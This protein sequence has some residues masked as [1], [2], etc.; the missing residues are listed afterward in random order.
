MRAI[1]ATHRSEHF[2]TPDALIDYLRA[3]AELLVVVSHPFAFCRDRSSKV[4]AFA[5]GR[6]CYQKYH[7]IALPDPFA[8]V[9][10]LLLT[11]ADVIAVAR[12]FGAAFDLY[13]GADS[14]GAFTGLLL[15]RAGVVR[16]VIFYVLD[17]NP[18]RFGNILDAVYHVLFLTSARLADCI[19]NCSGR[20]QKL[21][22]GFGAE[23]GKNLLVPHGFYPH[24]KR[25]SLKPSGRLVYVGHL[26]EFC[27][28]DLVIQA[29]P[30]VVKSFPYVRLYVIGYG[31][32]ETELKERVRDLGLENYVEFLG[33]KAHEDVVEF[34]PTCDVGLATYMEPEYWTSVPKQGYCFL[35]SGIKIIEYL[36]SGLPVITTHLPAISSRIEEAPAGMVVDYDSTALAEAIKK[37]IADPDFFERCRTNALAMVADKAWDQI[38]S[39]ALRETGFN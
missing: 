14:L 15:R 35:D 6:L 29:L 21:L 36:G 17:Y 19:W 25:S 3:R 24:R 20:I 7:N 11:L 5:A 13:V 31:P 37:L 39:K 33:K 28:M 4:T 12:R 23:D 2:G 10:N 34:L 27:G 16:K 18:R 9:K 30:K 8:Y 32:A 1:V 22:K 26:T 38:F